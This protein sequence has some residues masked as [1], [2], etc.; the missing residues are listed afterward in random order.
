MD[1]PAI[2]LDDKKALKFV[3]NLLIEQL[4]KELNENQKKIFL[5]S[6]NNLSY[7]RIIGKY[8]IDTDATEF[9]K[10]GS[11]L[12]RLLENLWE[13][14]KNEINKSKFYKEFRAKVK[15]KWLAEQKKQQAQD[16][17]SSNSQDSFSG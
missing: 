7:D 12:F 6:W 5:G 13:L 16:S 15:Q 3:Q 1:I 10:T 11:S 14:P 2:E 8:E 4:G 9:R 17:T